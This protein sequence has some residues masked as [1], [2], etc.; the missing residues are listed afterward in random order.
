MGS[1]WVLGNARAGW[2]TEERRL[3]VC[4]W[5]VVGKSDSG[6]AG[7]GFGKDGG[8]G[9]RRETTWAS[10]RAYQAIPSSSSSESGESNQQVSKCLES[11]LGG[12]SPSSEPGGVLREEGDD[13]EDEEWVREGGGEGGMGNRSIIFLFIR[14]SL[15]CLRVSLGVGDM[16][17][18][19][20]RRR[21]GL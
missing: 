11:F 7:G 9:E 14:L 16:G 18:R 20:R 3:R 6:R 21:N 19:E 1:S 13:E 8:T 4:R 10:S 2:A 17:N 5:W 15:P 12:W